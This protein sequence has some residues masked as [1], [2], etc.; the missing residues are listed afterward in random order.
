MGIFAV[1]TILLLI[2][3]SPNIKPPEPAEPVQHRITQIRLHKGP[4]FGYCPVYTATFFSDG[5]ATYEG[6]APHGRE[7]MPGYKIGEYAGKVGTERFDALANL[8]DS[9][10]F[11]TW[12]DFTQRATD[13][14]TTKI[15]I[16]R[17]DST[18]AVTIYALNPPDEMRA[19]MQ[20][21][22]ALV[23]STKWEKIADIEEK[24]GE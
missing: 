22:E 13:L 7:P 8:A 20:R 24:E 14:P 15:F 2:A 3:F 5:R 4:C 10:G 11:F 21:L 23:D 12:T 6:K 19:L 18:H 1:Y 9:L 16:T 17:G